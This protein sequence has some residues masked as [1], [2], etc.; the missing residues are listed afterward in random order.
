MARKGRV[1]KMKGKLKRLAAAAVSAALLC[2]AIPAFAEEVTNVASGITP[3]QT[4]SSTST[5]NLSTLTDG[6]K[7]D[8]T[9]STSWFL[10]ADYHYSQNPALIFD[11][12]SPVKVSSFVV[13]GSTKSANDTTATKDY[14]LAVNYDISYSDNGSDWTTA[15]EVRGNT[16]YENVTEIAD[17]T[18]R[19]W[20][21][22]V[23]FESKTSGERARICEIEIYGVE[24]E[25]G[26]VAEVPQVSMTE[27]T[28]ELEEGE[29][30]TVSAEASC[31]SS[32][33]KTVEF[34]NGTT[35]LADGALSDGVWTA[36]LSGLAAGEYLVTAKATTEA[37][38]IG[39]SDSMRVRVHSDSYTNIALNK[40][41]TA[42][43]GSTADSYPEALVDGITDQGNGIY[44]WNANTANAKNAWAEIDL[45]S[46]I[47]NLFLIN[48][49]T[50]RSAYADTSS[51]DILTDFT[52]SYYDGSEW[53]EAV[54]VEDAGNT[55][56]YNFD[57]A[58]PATK[59]K[60]VSNQTSGFRV[61]EIEV[62]GKLYR[63]P[64]VTVNSPQNVYEDKVELKVSAVD[65]GAGLADV[66]V[67]LGGQTAE[68]E[69]VQNG[70][71][72]TVTVTGLSGGENTLLVR[73]YDKNG[74]YGESEQITVTY[75]S[76]ADFVTLLGQCTTAAEV[77]ALV[78]NNTELLGLDEDDYTDLDTYG[79]IY[80]KILADKE[81][82]KTA[83]DF[84][85]VFQTETAIK[86]LNSASAK[87]IIEII[88]TSLTEVSLEEYDGLS[89]EVQ[90][91][92]SEQIAAAQI[93]DVK[94]LE[95]LLGVQI[96]LQS[97]KYTAW[98]NLETAL[99]KYNERL[100][101]D[102]YTAYANL[103]STKKNVANKY[104]AS[105][106][107]LD[108]MNSPD[109][110]EEIFTQAVKEGKSYTAS[111]SGGS[112]GGGGGG[113]SSTV[114]IIGQTAPNS[115]IAEELNPYDDVDKS[116]GS[117]AAIMYLTE[118]GVMQGDGDRI[119][120][121]ERALKREEF[122]RILVDG[123][124][125]VDENAKTTF[126][127]VKESDWFY[128][129]VATGQQMELIAGM[130]QYRFGS[131]E[132]VTREQMAVLCY[133][134]AVK[135]GKTFAA[136]GESAVPSDEELISSWAYYPI[137]LL[138]QNGIFGGE[139]LRPTEA[140]TRAEAAQLL[141]EIM[142]MEE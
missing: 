90:E 2:Q 59:V 45:A 91:A 31:E 34:Y 28:T 25:K 11:L 101:L 77:G 61:R 115:T 138:R 140:A 15:A 36:E 83:A 44:K 78:Q 100:G 33:I 67:L 63:K 117:W 106:K 35:K 37:G 119:F 14:A 48:S 52:L 20:K 7:G 27:E 5:G 88:R 82:I 85:A 26:E 53:L 103:S 38:G 134:A 121:P 104:I 136:E 87:E 39:E 89:D 93:T 23:I 19:Y 40:A 60:L 21:I 123:F 99:E 4:L 3:T 1:I 66:E 75:Y 24:G 30:V 32:E 142:L 107:N 139:T 131:G 71:E 112:G 74:K 124:F 120:A 132:Y 128:S 17:I 108:G 49:I 9:S 113:G 95:E 94:Q 84:I 13:T 125:G 109:G 116:N 29:T 55:Y 70:S 64:T 72:Y 50:V 41:T 65:M 111:S 118:K 80:A 76:S 57:T 43:H 86:M 81:N 56:T 135:A 62:V 130:E 122:A 129:Y 8:G 58:V 114:T 69:I 98:T 141:Y 18:A 51:T 68:A 73:V 102:D 10:R 22:F 46:G 42:E 47:D 16:N 133:R 79:D 96:A 97:I 12:G 105:K 92:V 6:I 127:D 137:K 110:F 126:T 54:K